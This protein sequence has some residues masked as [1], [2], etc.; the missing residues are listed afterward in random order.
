MATSGTTAFSLDLAEI[1]EEAHEL[2][3]LDYRTGW[4][5]K[6][7]RRALDLLLIEWG[8]R[9]YNLWA[10]DQ[11]S[12]TMTAS[13][14]T[15]TLTAATVD[16][17]EANVVVSSTE[18]P[19]RR[20]PAVD[21]MKIPNKTSTGRPNSY[22][23]DRQLAGPT[24]YL[25]PTPDQAYTLKYWRLRRLE[26]TGGA[27][28]TPDIPYRFIPALTAGLAY[29]LAMKNPEAASRLASLEAEYEKQWLLASEEDRDKAGFYVRPAIGR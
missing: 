3:G 20:I 27:T 24:M 19:M 25:W 12:T 6:T 15:V 9:G 17:I 23:I 22:W 5:F 13:T 28:Y 11:E 1:L 16:V 26:D 14:A 10:I 18:Y 8:N 29:R 7:G 4:Q 2:A 21:Y